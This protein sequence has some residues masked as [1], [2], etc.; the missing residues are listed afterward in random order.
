MLCGFNDG[1]LIILTESV[2]KWLEKSSKSYFFCLQLS[3]CE[4]WIKKLMFESLLEKNLIN[5]GL[6]PATVGKA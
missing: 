3:L 6:E 4:L 1:A 2:K 5:G